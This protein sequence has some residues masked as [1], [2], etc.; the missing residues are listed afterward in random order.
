MQTQSN[1][2]AALRYAEAGYPVFPCAAS[3]KRPATANGLNDA[4]TDPDKIAAWWNANPTANVAIR[5]DGLLVL[6]LDALE[7]GSPN[8]WLADQPERLMDLAAG[9]LSLT[10]RGGRHYIFK[11]PAGL[12]LRNTAGK[13]APG[14][15]TRANG[16]YILAPPSEVGGKR[17]RWAGEARLDDT[18][19]DSLPEPPG[20]LLYLLAQA[21]KPKREAA[22]SG[23]IHRNAAPVV[24]LDD[25]KPGDDFS[26]RASW[27]E[28]L[29]PH[30]WS[31]DGVHDGAERWTRP[32]KQDG[33]SGTAGHCKSDAGRDLF[34]CFTPNAP[35]LEAGKTYSKFALFATLNHGGDFGAAAEALEGAGVWAAR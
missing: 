2:E 24:A 22:N 6:D 8:P 5:T 17:Y 11:Q 30:G 7:D 4:S 25:T 23:P 12:D 16:G 31:F 27:A 32:G 20:W 28:I 10:P 33:V 26:A 15:D 1:F 29:E 14:V 19:R 21:D 34:Y 3:Q 35:P 13:L 18:A 9:P